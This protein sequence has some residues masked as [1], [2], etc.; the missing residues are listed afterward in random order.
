VHSICTGTFLLERHARVA[1]DPAA[2][3]ISRLVPPDPSR[4]LAYYYEYEVSSGIDAARA[5]AIEAQFIESLPEKP[6]PQFYFHDIYRFLYAC[7]FR[8][9]E[10]LPTMSE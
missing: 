9:G 5:E 1:A 6:F 10:P 2:Y 3:G 4:D 7:Q 8:D